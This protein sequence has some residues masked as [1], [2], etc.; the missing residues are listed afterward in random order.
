MIPVSSNLVIDDV[1]VTSSPSVFPPIV[2]AISGA[3][4]LLLGAYSMKQFPQSHGAGF[5]GHWTSFVFHSVRNLLTSV[6]TTFSDRDMI[7]FLLS[8]GLGAAAGSAWLA[9]LPVV[10]ADVLD[11]SAATIGA[12]FIT[13]LL[14][15]IAGGFLFDKLAKRISYSRALLVGHG[16]YIVGTIAVVMMIAFPSAVYLIWPLAALIGF[17][18][19]AAFTLTTVVY[20]SMI[21]PGKEVEYFGILTFFWKSFSWA[22]PLIFAIINEQSGRLNVAVL[23]IGGIFVLVFLFQM[24]VRPRKEPSRVIVPVSPGAVCIDEQQFEHE[25]AEVAPICVSPRPIPE[26]NAEA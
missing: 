14:L 16:L 10:F 20:S 7:C 24:M 22:G 15:S 26:A 9:I 1:Q 2:T 21:P 6:K 18:L 12:V 17:A 3:F 5:V 25:E 8:Q 4:F 23:S 11:L 13:A 19:G